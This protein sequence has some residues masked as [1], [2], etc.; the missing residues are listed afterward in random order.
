VAGTGSPSGRD[1]VA[2]LLMAYGGPE[3]PEDV[4][5]FLLDVRGGRPTPAELVEEIRGRYAAIGGGS[6]LLAISR[7]QAAAV[8]RALRESEGEGE[9]EGTGWRCFVGMRHWTPYVREAVAEI[10]AAG[11]ERLVALCLAPHYSRMSVGAYHRALDAALAAEAE[12]TGRRIEAMR[13]AGWGDE[14]AFLDA[15]AR[16][17]AEG[18]AA[19]PEGER[20]GVHVLFTAHSLPARL[21]AEGDPYADELRQTAA[22]VAERIG[23]LSWGFC[24]QSQAAGAK[25]WLGPPLEDEIARL[26]TAGVGSLLVA[27]IGFVA[28]HVEVLFDLDVEAKQLAASV[29]VRLER[30]ASLNDDD[31]F[32]AALAGVVRNALST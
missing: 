30:T 19:W 24:Y 11:F 16:R 8:E 13:V 23:D 18:L 21:V 25:D 3:R 31:D 17:V 4:E 7:R 26:A 22:A 6:P 27:P 5:P 2:V 9:G 14:P 12:E 1:R 10:A 29:G 32:A 20:D 28:D 15:V